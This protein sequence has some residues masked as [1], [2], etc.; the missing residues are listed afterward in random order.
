MSTT[1][2]LIPA[3]ACLFAA[4]LFGA[5]ELPSEWKYVQEMSVAGPGL[6]KFSLP[7]DTLGAARSGLEDIRI[8][9]DAGRETPHWIDRPASG[10]KATREARHFLVSL[11]S[12]STT[13]RIETGLDK[14]PMDGITLETPSN[15]FMK[16]VRV[17]GSTDGKNWKEL[18]RGL[19]IFRQANGASHLHLAVPSGIWKSLRLTVDDSRS[20][21]IAFT[22][23]KVDADLTEPLPS[24]IQTVRIVDRQEAEGQTR[25]TLDFGS[26]NL[27]LSDLEIETSEPLFMRGTTLA[28]R[29]LSGNVVREQSLAEGS[30]YRVGI[31]GQPVSS[32]SRFRLDVFLPS[33]EALLLIQNNDSP[34]LPI[35]GLKARR[36]PVYLIF[37]AKNPG[38]HYLMTGNPYCSVPRYDLGSLSARLKGAA[39][40][41]IH[42]SSLADNRFYHPSEALPEIQKAG[43]ALEV[44]SPLDVS[45]W[46]YRKKVG[47]S[48]GGVQ[49][50]A[51]DLEV[52][53]HSDASF[54]DLR[55]MRDEKQIPYILERT[56]IIESLAPGVTM[57][58][59]PKKPTRTRWI[60][61]LP[62]RALPLMRLACASPTALFKRNM[63]L[64]EESRDE[65][66]QSHQRIL[67]QATWVQTPA[68]KERTLTLHLDSAPF[69]DTLFLETDNGDNPAIEL[70]NFRLFYPV[71]RQIFKTASEAGV[72]LYYGNREAGSPQYDLDLM[73]SQLLSSEQTKASLAAEE[74]LREATWR[75]RAT[76]PGASHAIFWA[77]LVLVVVVLLVMISR[78]LPKQG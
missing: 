16:A 24:E 40:S 9:D 6:V 75:E 44:G 57:E 72:F 60:I 61:R 53:A 67:A 12:G 22:G 70:G 11:G 30:V 64:F 5:T 66:G 7:S 32:N 51:L 13:I 71:T 3:A 63:T 54:R 62:H 52:L 69:T 49:Y 45:R 68:L 8:F 78:L 4:A 56:S 15:G 59:V 36:R 55:L 19:P 46:K 35:H 77:V 74:I 38:V 50:L 26:A 34:P 31:E 25:L 33:R 14:H 18:G 1:K 48:K 29:Q 58:S 28:T 37:Q 41:S 42:V 43:S 17:E 2:I 39:L 10:K 73:T 47:L 65:R 23:A 76:A 27:L 21:P 20:D